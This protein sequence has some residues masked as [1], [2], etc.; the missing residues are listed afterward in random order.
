MLARF[1]FITCILLTNL[2]FSQ[3]WDYDITDANMT[4]QISADVVSF[5]G[6]QPPIGALLGAFYVNDL[7]ELACAGYQEWSGTQLA[8]ALWASESGADNGFQ[9]SEDINWLLQVE[10][11]TYTPSVSE[12]NE[13]APFSL[14]FIPNGFGQVLDLDFFSSGCSDVSACNYCNSCLEFDDTLCEY[15]DSGYDC[16][17]NCINDVDFDSICDEFE[18][19]GCTDTEATN[20]SELAT[21]DDGSCEYILY[22]CTNDV[23]SNFNI[24]ATDDDGSCL[25][26]GDANADNYYSGDDGTFCSIDVLNNYTLES[27]SD[28]LLDCCFYANPG[29]TDD[30]SCFDADGD[31]DLD[32]CADSFLYID[33]ET[34]E[35]V[36]YQSPFPGVPAANYNPAANVLVGVSYC[37]YFPACQ[38]L[39]AM[40]YGY[41]Y[42]GDDVLTLAQS[43]GFSVDYNEEPDSAPF[44]IVFNSFEIVFE[45]SNNCCL[46]Y[47]CDD[48]NADNFHDL[49]GIFYQNTPE[50]ENYFGNGNINF[51]AMFNLNGTYEVFDPD[52]PDWANVVSS[53][54]S[55]DI[56]G[57]GILNNIDSDPD[58]DA[59]NMVFQYTNQEDEDEFN[60][61]IYLGCKDDTAINYDPSANIDDGTCQYYACEDPNSMNYQS[62]EFILE[63]P[64]Y[65]SCSDIDFYDNQTYVPIP[66]GLNDCCQYLGCLDPTAF[67]YSPAATI[68]EL[69][70]TAVNIGNTLIFQPIPILSELGDTIGYEDTCFPFIYGCQDDGFQPW[71]PS[72]GNSAENY[73]DYDG[74]G[75]SDPFV[76]NTGTV[77][78]Q[79][80]D[81]YINENGAGLFGISQLDVIEEFALEYGGFLGAHTNVNSTPPNI[82]PNSV[83]PCEYIYGCTDPCYIEYYNVVEY[84]FEEMFDFSTINN[85]LNNNGCDFDYNYGCT[86]LIPPA[87]GNIPTFDDGSCSNALVYGCMDPMAANY[88]P[89]ATINDCL[90]CIPSILI[91]FDVSNPLCYDQLEGVLSFSVSGGVGSY[92]YSLFNESGNLV[93][94]ATIDGENIVVE[95]DVLIGDYFLEVSDSENYTSVISFSVIES[96]DFVIDLWESGG[97]LNTVEGYDIYEWTLNGQPLVGLDFETSQIYPLESGLYGVTAYF[98]HDSE[99]CVSNTVYYNYDMF[100]SI[101]NENNDFSI[102]CV[103]N[104]LTNEARVFINKSGFFQLY[105]DLY[106]TFGKKVWNDTKIIN[107]EKSFILN[108]LPVGMYYFRVTALNEVKTIPIIVLK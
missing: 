108:E 9:V 68:Q 103:P 31:G 1:S 88:N 48:E 106:D 104:P 25:F 35:S 57:D 86:E 97:W 41:N 89:N 3:D 38:D 49:D 53:L 102:S 36:Y 15:P 101:I 51:S 76:S 75:E 50:S 73:N 52:L 42:N 45:E 96:S 19:L 98:E 13:D 99:L 18:I 17:G 23:A 66:D 30:G 74:D 94:Q 67:N 4:I 82:D 80:T 16:D 24:D 100:Q 90:S 54:S 64:N 8:I 5:D 70:F 107:E 10:G 46:Y 72:P 33:Q 43:Y 14:T 56:D 27:G 105:I 63:N 44:S 91:D 85:M 32:E 37:H 77:I 71:S 7:G 58:N 81:T 62:A 26:C 92:T 2:M 59:N 65:L 28:G 22:G 40:N 11:E 61:C 60:P 79:L 20:Y 34:G 69:V 47:G 12:M 39:N 21:D 93:N 6:A 29:C 78:Y 55:N 84:S 87:L 83:E 95:I